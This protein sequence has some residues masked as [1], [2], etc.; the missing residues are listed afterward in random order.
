MSA[1]RCRV[2]RAKVLTKSVD[3]DEEVRSGALDLLTDSAEALKLYGPLQERQVNPTS[4]TWLNICNLI[5]V[6]IL[7]APSIATPY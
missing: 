1:S 2:V 6:N 3:A 4:L 5:R 7:A